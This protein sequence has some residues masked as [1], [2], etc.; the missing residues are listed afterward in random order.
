[1][2]AGLTALIVWAT[3]A[4]GA[5]YA[6]G[7]VPLLVGCATAGLLGVVRQRGV[8]PETRWPAG[9]L[10]LLGVAGAAQLV[11]LP[12][13][14]VRRLDPALAPLLDRYDVGYAISP[15]WHALSVDP[16]STE[17][18][19]AF[20]A[21]YSLFVAGLPALL[22]DV[23]VRR[24]ARNLVLFGVGLS[25]FG[26]LQKQT[27]NGLMYWFWQ[28]REGSAGN[29]FGPFVD[30]DHFAGWMLLAIPVGIGLLT[31]EW[32][33]HARRPGSSLRNALVWLSTPVGGRLTLLAVGLSVM[34]IAQVWTLSRSG[35]GC[36]LV[37]FGLFGWQGRR[38]AAIRRRGR[39]I[40]AYVVAVALLALAWRGIG[41]VI[42]WY[43]DTRDLFGR[44]AAW[45]D[46]WHVIRSFPLFGTGLGTYSI[47]ML[48]YQRSNLPLL[49][50]QAHNDYLQLAAEGGLLLVVPAATA[51]GLAIREI[52][53]RFREGNDDLLGYWLRVGCVIGLIVIAIQ[54]TADFSLQM[55]A[56]AALFCIVLVI[57]LR[58][59]DAV[60]ARAEARGFRARRSRI[61]PARNASQAG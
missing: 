20:L 7:Y 6:W 23:T 46:G 17:V 4:F 61:S 51:A 24:L 5:V 2:S 16:H 59:P 48:F 38:S 49:L 1:M 15:A 18:S 30:R 50:R 54:E 13:E 3:L 11:P 21:A 39:G 55:P 36:L 10:L 40:V 41:L 52:R 12:P 43:G 45:G 29:A 37:A 56:N 34:T 31:G 26:L 60:V 47:A 9:A 58:R 27:S 35:I 44:F 42:A 57:A 22:S 53:R 33:A 19:L 8:P 25:L 14:V 28:P 32:V